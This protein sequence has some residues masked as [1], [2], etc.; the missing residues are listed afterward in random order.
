M[1][2]NNLGNVRKALKGDAKDE[3][4]AKNEDATPTKKRKLR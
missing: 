2:L 1:T 4:A 3:N